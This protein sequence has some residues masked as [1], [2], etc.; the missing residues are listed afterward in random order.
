[1]TPG[2]GGLA[3]EERNG[4]G[5]FRAGRWRSGRHER[6][7]ERCPDDGCLWLAANVLLQATYILIAQRWPARYARRS[8]ARGMRSGSAPWRSCCSAR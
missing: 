2:G 5:L 7:L 6:L 4:F 3:A 1:M 8:A